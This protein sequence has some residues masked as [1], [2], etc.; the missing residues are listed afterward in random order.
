VQFALPT[1]GLGG[2][3]SGSQRARVAT[4]LWGLGNLYCANCASPSLNASPANTPAIDFE[5]PNCRA[6]FQLKSQSHAFGSKIVDAAY[7]K[8]VREI[9]LNR[10]PNLLAL[11]YDLQSWVVRDVLLIPSFAFPLSSPRQDN[12]DPRLD[13]PYF[14]LFPLRE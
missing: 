3:T 10:T 1:A 14:R 11:R 5:C 8:M 9:E 2:Y 4:E 12:N 7:S 13:A 6:S